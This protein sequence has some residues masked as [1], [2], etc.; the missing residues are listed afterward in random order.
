MSA[1]IVV[2]AAV[3]LKRSRGVLLPGRFRAALSVLRRADAAG[4]PFYGFDNKRFTVEAVNR[5]C[6]RG[7][8]RLLL[9]A[10]LPNLTCSGHMREA[11]RRAIAD[12]GIE[13]DVLAGVHLDSN[14]AEFRLEA[15]RLASRPK[16]PDGVICANETRSLA[17]VAGLQDGRLTVGQGIDVI[18]KDTLRSARPRH[19]VDRL[20]LRGLDLRWRGT[21]A[22]A[23]HADR[24][25]HR[26]Q[27][28]DDRRTAVPPPPDLSLAR[29]QRSA[30]P[31]SSASY[32][33]SDPPASQLEG[34]E[35]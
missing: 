12:A 26:R 6:E 3:A 35:P 34:G 8:K 18:G 13:G 29:W 30:I 17:L 15:K 4:H 22:S 16:A 24:R 33:P 31:S 27:A 25:C 20:V 28:T 9:I 5:L 2:L 23:A 32:G 11:F 10:P 21:C 7:R 1:G 19:A 14:P